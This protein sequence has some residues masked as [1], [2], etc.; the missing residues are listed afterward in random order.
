MSNEI[1]PVVRHCDW[2]ERIPQTH[3][4]AQDLRITTEIFASFSD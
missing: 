3:L 2:T 1:V 4:Q